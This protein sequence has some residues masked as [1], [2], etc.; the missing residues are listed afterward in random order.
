MAAGFYLGLASSVV[1]NKYRRLVEDNVSQIAFRCGLC[2][3]G[4]M[5]LLPAVTHAISRFFEW[6]D[7]PSDRCAKC[8]YCLFGLEKPR[9]PECGTPIPQRQVEYLAWLERRRREALESTV[10]GNQLGGHESGR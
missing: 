2:F 7:R 6:R 8:G 9:C 1:V 5:V 10:D 3:V 4:C